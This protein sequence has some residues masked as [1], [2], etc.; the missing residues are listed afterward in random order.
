MD[1]LPLGIAIHQNHQIVFVNKQALK[2][3][4][5][6]EEKQLLGKNISEFVKPDYQPIVQKRVQNI[7]NKD[8]EA[9]PIEEVL[10]TLDKKPIIA[11][12][13]AKKDSLEPS[14]SCFSNF[15]GCIATTS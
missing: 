12:V 13:R 4:N 8:E 9:P 5:A 6:Q 7:Y 2:L 10:L 14:T 11:E 3:L 1:Y 15:S